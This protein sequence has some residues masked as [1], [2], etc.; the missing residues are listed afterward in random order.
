LHGIAS[1]NSMLLRRLTS[2]IRVANQRAMT[3]VKALVL[4]VFVGLMIQ[5]K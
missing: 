4:E 2:K 1:R 5:S 3:T